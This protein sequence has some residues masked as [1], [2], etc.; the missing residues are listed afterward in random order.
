MHA[1]FIIL[2]YQCNSAY[3]YRVVKRTCCCVAFQQRAATHYTVHKCKHAIIGLSGTNT[4]AAATDAHTPAAKAAFPAPST[5]QSITPPVLQPAKCLPPSAD[6]CP[7]NCIHWVQKQ[8]LPAL[9][10]VMQNRVER[11]NVGVMM[12]GQGRVTDVFDATMSFMKERK[13]KEEAQLRAKR[14][15]SPAQEEARRCAC[16]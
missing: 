5:L 7:V 14:A 9:E 6:S 8:D 11:V 10:Y 2:L 1:V 3:A 13:R 12:A 16:L 15:Y 4:A